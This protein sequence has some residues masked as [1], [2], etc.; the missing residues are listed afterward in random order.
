MT[1][2][3]LDAMKDAYKSVV[4]K[5]IKGVFGSIFPEAV[6]LAAERIVAH[7]PNLSPDV[8]YHDMLRRF[9]FYVE[10][11]PPDKLVHIDH[12]K[13]HVILNARAV[14][15]FLHTDGHSYRFAKRKE[16]HRLERIRNIIRESIAYELHRWHAFEDKFQK[17]EE[18]EQVPQAPVREETSQSTSHGL[19]LALLI[20]PI[21]LLA[22]AAFNMASLAERSISGMAVGTAS[23]MIGAVFLFL[24]V[25]VAAHTLRKK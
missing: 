25:L 21:L 1:K 19:E 18:Q 17:E 20:T 10:P 4:R 16:G 15:D 2:R 11:T 8:V 24:A 13:E 14:K 7:H 9:R 23:S 6:R 3:Y 5:D 22:T 12:E